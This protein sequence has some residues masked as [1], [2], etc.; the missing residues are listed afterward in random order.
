MMRS[1]IGLALLSVSW[2]LGMGYYYPAQPLAWVVVV[3][4]GTVLL[5]GSIDRLPPR[6]ETL[7]TLALLVPIVLF[8]PWPLRAAPLLI[9]AGLALELLP[10]PRRWPKPL[11]R[12]AVTAG[13]VMLAQ[14][15]SMAAYA[16]QTARSHELPWPLPE[17]LAGVA[18]LLGIDATADGSSVVMHSIRQVHRLAATWE[19]LVDPPT[20]CFFVGSLVFFALVIWSRL[21][22]GRRWKPWIGILRTLSLVIVVWLPV[23]AG[24]LVALYLHRVLRSDYETPLHVMNQ[25]L[26]PWVHLLLLIPPVLLAWRFVRVPTGYSDTTAE[27]SDELPHGESRP[28]HYP[29]AA[30]LIL[31]VVVL[32][33]VGIEWDPVGRR[34]AGRVMVVERHSTWEPTT[35]PYDTRWFG[36]DSGYNY[37]AV[38]SYLSQ[39]F[40]MSRLL[41]SDKIDHQ[42]LARCDV[43]VIKT[44]TARYA[45]EEVD[46]VVRFVHSGGGL[47]LVGDHTNYEGCG[48]FINDITRHMGF[49][50]RHDLLFG[51]GES[52]YDQLY[53]PPRVPHPIVQHLPPT[54]FA[55]SC[56]IDPGR[57]RGRAVIQESGLWSLPPD[58]H[59][60]NYHT[61]PQHRPDMRYGAFIQ[62][63]STHYGKGRVLAFGDSTIFSNFCTFQPGKAELLLGMIEWLN[64]RGPGDPRPWLLAVGLLPLAVGLYLARTREDAWLVLLAAGTCGWVLASV[65][66]AGLHRRSMPVPKTVRPMVR[67]VIDRTVSQVPLS[68]GAYIQGEGEGYGM[69]EQWIS[70]LGY[71]TIRRSGAG[72]FSGDL[73]V[74]ICPSRSV[75]QEFRRRL[76]DYVAGGGKLL[77]IDSPKNAA[78]TANSLLWPFGLSVLFDQPWRGRL[79]LGEG[80]PIVPVELAYEI[81]GGRPVG[82][83]GQRPVAAVTSYGKGRVMAV[84]FGSLFNDKNMGYTWTADPKEEMLQRYDVLF[85]LVRSLLTGKPAPPP[86]RRKPEGK[87]PPREKTARETR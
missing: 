29:A 66:V 20:L 25:F 77:V 8:A 41:E 63:W 23:R 69:A 26:S 58:Y 15:L 5:F 65:A 43:L 30:V 72:A 34:Q 14:A 13:V 84:G 64:H 2:L 51:T 28:W 67:A 24:L 36:H 71:Y 10:V 54:D 3:A 39:F 6:R 42:T 60:G 62:L 82:R 86:A 50:L 1:W 9:V 76:V 44:P 56:S 33:T 59:I 12:A 32:F 70:R 53:V 40:K 75:T 80:W 49:T 55:V 61:I 7:I 18:R 21:P 78:S 57:S 45:K 19:L 81:A 85:A 48:T 16:G 22:A 73:L 74:V 17:M 52:P 27:G 46:A 79:S 83:L 31:L 87:E 4:G 68:K 38:Y 11:A 47:L 35:K 37:A